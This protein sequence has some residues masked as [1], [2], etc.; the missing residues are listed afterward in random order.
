MSEETD[1]DIWIKHAED[2]FNAA[3]KLLRGKK[4]HPFMARVFTPSNAPKNTYMK[5]MLIAKGKRFPMIHDLLVIHNLLQQAGI[6]MKVSEDELAFLS[7]FAV[8]ARYSGELPEITDAK[9][10]LQI[11]KTVRKFSR[12]FLNLK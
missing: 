6:N 10:A 9:E 4:N 1:L 11:A 8:R 12:S 3:G 5:A 7:A 2:D